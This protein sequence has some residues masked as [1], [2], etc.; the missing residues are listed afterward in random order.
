MILF[1]YT[2]VDCFEEI[3]S[4]SKQDIPCVKLR[5]KHRSIVSD[6][7]SNTFG[8]FVLPQC[9]GEIEKELGIE[10]KDSLMPFLQNRLFMES[11]FREN[12]SFDDHKTGLTQFVYSLYEDVDDL[13]LWLRYGDNGTGVSIGL[14]TDKLKL[15]FGQAFNFFIKQC[16]YWPSSI[17]EPSHMFSI[18]SELYEEIK[19]M[20]KA[21]TDAK[22]KLAFEKLYATDTPEFAITQRIK[23]TLVH[24]LVSTYDLF[25]KRDIWQNEKEHRMTVSL[26]A[27]EIRYE[28]NANGDYDPYVVM[29]FPID[30]LKMVVIGPKCGKNA[31]GM[32][33][34]LFY[35]CQVKEKIQ[36]FYSNLKY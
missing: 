9:I 19:E 1:N 4:R 10:S 18:P 20:Y 12:R 7:L 8:L 31:Y 24:N 27:P 30:A 16:V 29:E 35:E 11:V 23:E 33:Q 6:D 34:S 2:S 5:L 22:V 26:M 14:D 21:T 13:D 3:L 15:P 32:I 36:V 28:K 25:H 17:T